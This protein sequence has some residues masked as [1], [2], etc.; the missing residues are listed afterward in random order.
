M[1]QLHGD[2]GYCWGVS[3]LRNAIDESG[4]FEKVYDGGGDGPDHT[5]L[6]T[7]DLLQ[8]GDILYNGP[9]PEENWGHAAMYI[10]NGQC[11]AAH[12]YSYVVVDQ[13][14]VYDYTPEYWNCVYRYK[15]DN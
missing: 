1:M 10:G 9:V 2:D 12:G 4:Q 14:N 3:G 6:V 5:V 15:G 11:V 13:I 8:P 7:E